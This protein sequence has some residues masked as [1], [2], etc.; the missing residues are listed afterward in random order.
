[1]K[2]LWILLFLLSGVTIGKVYE[3]AEPDLLEELENSKDKAISYLRKETE[4]LRKKLEDFTGEILTPAKEETVRYFYP[5]YC[6]KK[7]ILY[8]DGEEWR[9]LYP[10]GYCFNPVEYIPYDPPPMVVFNPCRKEEREWVKEYLEKNGSA[11]LVVSGCPIREVSSQNWNVPVYYLLPYI[12]ERF[13][14]RHTISVLS[15][16]RKKKAI[17]IEEISVSGRRGK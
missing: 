6:L 3:I 17:R 4:R 16:D 11:L 15:I 8:R 7:D 14:L 9:V 2:K 1:M 10:K 5:T 13:S 12:K